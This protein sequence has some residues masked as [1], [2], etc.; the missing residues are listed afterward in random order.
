MEH[1][2]LKISFVLDSRIYVKDQ[3]PSSIAILSTIHS[4]FAAYS[5]VLSANFMFCN[6][7][8]KAAMWDGNFFWDGIFWWYGSERVSDKITPSGNLPCS[9]TFSLI[10]ATPCKI[11]LLE[12]EEGH[13]EKDWKC[14]VKKNLTY[15]YNMY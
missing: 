13:L 8:R 7:A 3:T 1:V 6:V 5:S 4:A 10:N 14:G 9:F 11:K 2:W 12:V 15:V